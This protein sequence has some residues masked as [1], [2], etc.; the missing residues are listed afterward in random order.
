MRVHMR[1]PHAARL[2]RLAANRA[3]VRPLI[4]VDALVYR[5]LA[6]LH[7]RLAALGALVPFALRPLQMVALRIQRV[8]HL[9]AVRAREL[10]LRARR[11][12]VRPQR[13]ER[14]V[15]GAAMLAA[16]RL[17]V[18]VLDGDVHRKVPEPIVLAAALGQRTLEALQM[19]DQMVF[20]LLRGGKR[21]RA[22]AALVFA[23]LVAVIVE[24]LVVGVA[25]IF[26]VLVGRLQ[27]V[28]QAGHKRFVGRRVGGGIIVAAEAVLVLLVLLQV[29]HVGENEPTH[30]TRME[31]NVLVEHVDHVVHA[32]VPIE[33]LLVGKHFVALVALHEFGFELCAFLGLFRSFGR[34][35]LADGA[36]CAVLGV[37]FVARI[38]FAGGGK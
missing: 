10:L 27:Y 30:V 35:L 32:R 25:V 36:L 17:A 15:L 18:N 29:V 31:L 26:V 33:A 20:G 5:Q 16:V 37:V 22:D 12:N 34:R 6:A 2:E 24:E 19:V 13:I 4:R 28:S 1:H 21:C 11:I 7:E 8:E 23:A 3:H 38:G 9:V 14:G